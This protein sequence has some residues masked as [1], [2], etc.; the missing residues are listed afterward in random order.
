MERLKEYL[1]IKSSDRDFYIKNNDSIDVGVSNDGFFEN[2]SY[3]VDIVFGVLNVSP[4]KTG[5]K[6][7]KDAIFLY[8]FNGNL[9]VSMSREIYPAIAEKY[10]K[11]TMAIERAMRLCFENV[12]YHI[13]KIK[14][15]YI[16]EY[17]KPC[18]LYPHNSEIVVRIVKLI[19]SK[20]F[21]NNKNTFLNI[22]FFS[23]KI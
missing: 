17:L 7:F 16:A 22:W 15:N 20:I 23:H 6:Y 5:Y 8:I 1:E 2:V 3:D 4:S 19:S 11:T 21:Q 14:N 13:S 9:D 12:M 10:Q 18:L